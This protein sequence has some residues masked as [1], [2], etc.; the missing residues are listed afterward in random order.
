MNLEKLETHRDALKQ[1]HDALD[2]LIQEQYNDYT[3]DELLK[4]EKLKKLKLKREI[5]DINRTIES[6]S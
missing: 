3:T 4:E 1:K 6:L 2:K 5:D